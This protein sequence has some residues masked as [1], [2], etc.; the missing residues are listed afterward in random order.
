MEREQ[1]KCVIS[2]AEAARIIGVSRD[3]M[4]KLVEEKR[5]K[6]VPDIEPVRLNR[7]FFFRK[8]GITDPLKARKGGA[9]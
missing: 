3:K 7:E 6:I 1:V 5:Y 4:R 8:T 9:R 2:I